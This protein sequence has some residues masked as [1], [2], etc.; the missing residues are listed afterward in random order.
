MRNRLNAAALGLHLL[1]R[2]VET[3]DMSDAEATI[4]KIFNEL[5]AIENEL[6][7]PA[8]SKP[9]APRRCAPS[10]TRRRRQRQRAR[11]V[12]R[13]LAGRRF[14]RRYGGRRLAGDGSV[15]R[16][17]AGCRAT[18]YP[19][20]PFRWPQDDLRD[21]QESR[22]SW[23]EAIR[24]HGSRPEETDISVGPNG[25]DRWFVKPLNPNALLD[26]LQADLCI[27]RVLARVIRM[28]VGLLSSRVQQKK[29]ADSYRAG[30]L[31][32]SLSTSLTP[33]TGRRLS[34]KLVVATAAARA[35]AVATTFATAV[36]AQLLRA[37]DRYRNLL[38]DAFRYAAGHGVG[39]TPRHTLRDLDRPLVANWLAD[40]VANRTGVLLRHHVA[41]LVATSALLR[42]HVAN[43]VAD[44]TR[45]LLW[46]HVA[47]LVAAG[48]G[49]WHHLAGL[50]AHRA[51]ALFW[52]H[53]ANL[54]A[55]RTRML[56][57]HHV[58]DLVAAGLLF[59]HH[60]AGL[61]AHRAGALFWNHVADL[62]AAGP[63][64]WNHVANLVAD[65]AATLLGHH[66]ANLVAEGL[67]LRNHVANLVAAGLGPRFA[68]PL[69]AADLFRLALA[70]PMLLAAL[71]GGH[72][73]HSVWHSP[74]Q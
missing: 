62:V 14:R 72:C 19:H 71:G 42:N 32:V 73:T 29:R 69:R 15:D 10:G 59:W 21:S 61:P 33:H 63:L 6:E 68:D 5:K 2:N 35:T 54:V 20:A 27:E 9:I 50:P 58:A 22:L 30:P 67:L 43:L 70:Y 37:A 8:A 13:L 65:R 38:A 24:C 41:D 1:H 66:M 12:G 17:S 56:L 31:W 64:F 52:N 25:V 18:R 60:L 57:W 53:V 55:D 47:D 4:F 16:E 51:G 3:G 44:R 34:Y 23:A 45:T 26:A 46:H 36:A 11:T 49:F 39:D 74:G 48:L 40:R 7:Q 28:R